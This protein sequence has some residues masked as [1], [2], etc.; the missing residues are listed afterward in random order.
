MGGGGGGSV[1]V[2]EYQAP[3]VGVARRKYGELS[4][5]FQSQAEYEA[6]KKGNYSA[7]GMSKNSNYG[8]VTLKNGVDAASAAKDWEN[9]M[10]ERSEIATYNAKEARRKKSPDELTSSKTVDLSIKSQD[11]QNKDNEVPT[12]TQSY[13]TSPSTASTSQPLGIY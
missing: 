2:S 10:A 7:Y 6:Y 4:N 5:G 12:I 11:E 1:T 3:R 9:Y 13:D 8:T